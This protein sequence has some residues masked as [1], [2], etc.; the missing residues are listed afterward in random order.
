MEAS[1]ENR[2]VPSIGFW[3]ICV[4]VVLRVA[5]GTHFTGE[6]FKKFD[7]KFSSEIVLRA[8]KGPLAPVYYSMLPNPYR[9]NE[10]LAQPRQIGTLTDEEA[11]QRQAWAAAYRGKVRD[12]ERAKESYE[13]E[14]P[15]HAS[16]SDWAEAVKSA[17]RKKQ[18]AAAKA[19]D[20]EKAEAIY[21]GSLQRL[22]DYF[23]AQEDAIDEFRHNLWRL[24]R[25]KDE[26]GAGELPYVEERIDDTG[27]EVFRSAQKW[28]ADVQL[29]E[30]DYIEQLAALVEEPTASQQLAESLHT[31]SPLEWVNP[32]VKWT[33]LGVGG[34]LLLGL[35]TRLAAVVGAGF[36]LSVMASQ[37]P[38]VPGANLDFFGYQL[39]E[40]AAMLTVAVTGAGRWYG[41][42]S[43]LK[44]CC[45]LLSGP[46]E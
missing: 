29:L 18:A 8:A 28:P 4:L 5:L 32:L 19:G 14:F 31:P 38:W 2:R 9:Y 40:V 7:P 34:C 36:L 3:T 39:V 12:A 21:H 10:L 43:V 15:P 11:E 33:V 6:G 45:S 26:P 46:N 17:W 35:F 20:K 44:R 13:A 23:S 41:V 37:P 30:E 25:L 16:Y 22:A 27:G 24:E 42:D 1:T